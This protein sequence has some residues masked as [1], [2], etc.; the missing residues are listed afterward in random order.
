MDRYAK[1]CPLTQMEILNTDFMKARNNLLEIAAFLDRMD[2]ARA[3]DGEQ[4]FRMVAFRRVLNDLAGS[5][6]DKVKRIQ[7]GLSD[8]C[9]EP[10]LERDVQ[11]AFGAART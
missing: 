5:A 8:L 9:I 11:N 1:S 4:D 7:M 2:R 3:L 10:M 6:P